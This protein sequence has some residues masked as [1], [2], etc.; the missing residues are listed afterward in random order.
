M[1]LHPNTLPAGKDAKPGTAKRSLKRIVGWTLAAVVAGCVAFAA[2]AAIYP[3]RMPLVIGTVVEDVTGANPRP[4][5]LVLPPQAPLSAVAQL[6]REIFYDTSLSASGKQSCASCHSPQHAYGPPNNL[7]VQL[8]GPHMNEAGYRPPPSLTYLYRQAPFSIGPDQNDMDTAPVSLQDLAASAAGVQ[9]AVKTAGVAPAAPAMVP[10]GGLFWD[11]RASTLQ[12]QAI[13]PMLNPVEMANASVA[14]VAHKLVA[15]KYLDQ[16]KL[17]FGDSIAYRP[18]LLVSEAMFAVGRYQYED[19]SF[20][21]FTSKYDYWLQGKARLTQAELHG[22]RLFNDPDK[23]NCA[24]CHLSKP[25]ADGLPPLFTDTQYEAL[26]VPRNPRLPQNKDPKFYDMGV[27]G[28]FRT[29]VKDLTQYCG[30]FLTPTLRNVATR[31]VFFHNGVYHDLQHVMDFYNLR[32]TNPD[33]IY[34]KNASG[35]VEQYDDLPAQYHA[36]IDVADAPFDRKPGDKPAMTDS[37]IQ[38]IIAFIN[39]LSDGYKP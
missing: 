38:D 11:G 14:D 1:S 16:F 17:L 30:M 32:N 37:E 22:L 7:E 8:G 10:Q 21:P 39:T 35:K 4:V 36:N 24:G 29:D 15:T 27:C 25:T 23:A 13:G 31:H 9:R 12:D 19:A 34:P 2:Y 28:P 20:H 33:K 5:H 3:E 26:G 18:E 6:G